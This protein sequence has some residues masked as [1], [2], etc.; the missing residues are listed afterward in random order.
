MTLM[1]LAAIAE[2]VSAVSVVATLIYLAIQVR[3]SKESLDANT[4]AMR[5][6]VISDV[7][8]NVQEHMAIALQGHDLVDTL[9][10][11][12]TEPAL[13]PDD[14][15][16]LDGFLTAVFIARQNEF[17]QW[18]QGLLDD[19]VFRSLH[20]ITLTVLGSESGRHWWQNEGCNLVSAEFVEFTEALM[21]QGATES[22]ES[23]RRANHLANQP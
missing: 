22:I 23:W 17:Y 20:H 8:K 4:R 12:A 9:K 7:T 2:V 13:E 3:H 11:M 19:A 6:Q 1:E 18:K 15:L 5:G 16:L 21:E 10:K 14:A